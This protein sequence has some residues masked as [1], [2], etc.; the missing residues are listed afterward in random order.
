MGNS[1]LEQIS[2]NLVELPLVAILEFRK[3]A[4]SLMQGDYEKADAMTAKLRA[5]V[6]GVQA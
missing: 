6:E 5:E 2:A 4:E 1:V 3:F